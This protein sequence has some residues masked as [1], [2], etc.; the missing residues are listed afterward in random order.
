LPRVSVMNS[1]N[2]P[3]PGWLDNIYGPIGLLIAG[4]KGALRVINHSKHISLNMIPID[5][6]V[7]TVIAVP[8]KLGLTK[9]D[10]HIQYIL[11]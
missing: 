4:G 6:V 5:L 3:F 10:E 9:Y 8:W 1:I 2:D 11:H 7:K